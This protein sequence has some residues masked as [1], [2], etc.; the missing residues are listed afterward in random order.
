MSLRSMVCTRCVTTPHAHIHH[1]VQPLVQLYLLYTLYIAVTTSRPV[2][3]V[4]ELNEV[5]RT[6]RAQKY[7][8]KPAEHRFGQFGP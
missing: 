1:T 6:V 2:S 5:R 7:I 4:A 3:C 8:N